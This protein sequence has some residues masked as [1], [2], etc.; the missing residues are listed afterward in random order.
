MTTAQSPQQDFPTTGGSP[1][2]IPHQAP[3][4]G[5]LIRELGTQTTLRTQMIARRLDLNVN[6]LRALEILTLGGRQSAGSLATKLG[7]RSSS[8]T[9]LVDRLVELGYV[10]R[11]FDSRDRRKI[12]IVVD[13]R[14]ANEFMALYRSSITRLQAIYKDFTEEELELVHRFMS[15]FR[16]ASVAAT[17]Q[18]SAELDA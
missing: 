4:I 7:L 17:E 3:A 14:R 18:L 10:R 8:T 13:E 12:W 11:E 16:D 9:A 1:D 15:K 5:R 6:D 2:E